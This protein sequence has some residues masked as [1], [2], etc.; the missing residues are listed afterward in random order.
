MVGSPSAQMTTTVNAC[1][2]NWIAGNEDLLLVRV[3]DE[4]VSSVM[5]L[6]VTF[7]SFVHT[8]ELDIVILGVRSEQQWSRMKF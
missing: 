3:L 5:A 7:V 6:T 1:P 4:L 2:A 8:I